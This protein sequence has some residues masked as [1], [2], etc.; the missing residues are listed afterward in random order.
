MF[1]YEVFQFGEKLIERRPI[2]R[3]RH[4]I[5]CC[6]VRPILEVFDDDE[7]C[8]RNRSHRDSSCWL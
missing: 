7:R 1:R 3:C 5:G 8:H 2:Q 6:E 4:A